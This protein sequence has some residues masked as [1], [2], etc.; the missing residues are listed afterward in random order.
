LTRALPRLRRKG[1]G[2]PRI[3]IVRQTDLYE[4][5]VKREAE[6]LARAGYETEV[7]LMR[8]TERP[9]RAVVDGGVVLISLPARLGRSSKAR[10]ALDYAW[11]WLLAATTLAVRHLRRPYDVVQVNTMPDFLVFAAV[12]PKLLGARVVAY[13]KE[14]VPEL[15]ETLYGTRRLT[16]LLERFEQWA[17]RFADHSLTVT[18][19]LKRLYVERGAPAER[20]T[21][22]LNGADAETLRARDEP[23]PR[24]PGFTLICHGSIEERY[25]QDT[26]IE[27]AALL[28]DELPDLRV[29]FI[30]RGGFAAEMVRR[31]QALGLQD[32]VRF[33]GW[34]TLDRMQDLLRA[35]DA[36][37]VAQKASRYSH[38]V[39]TNK[40]VDY[41]IFGLPVVA[42]R[43]RATAALYDDT[44]I[45]YFAPGDA[46]D[47]AR[48]IARLQDDPRR[49]DELARNGRAAHARHGW[50]VQREAYLAPFR[51][52]TATGTATGA[53]RIAPP[54]G[55]TSST[56][57]SA[58]AGPR[59]AQPAPSATMVESA[60][61]RH[62][63]ATSRGSAVH[64]LGSGAKRA[65][66]RS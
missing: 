44:V 26:I 57:P 62:H 14:P 20:I 47:L 15:T 60:R 48:A 33:D 23:P 4:V 8:S 16:P 55:P 39:H 45:E 27:A 59:I 42:S 1:A 24:E 54:S 52:L 29:V 25:G 28:R 43:L 66:K 40:M 38:L 3:C 41:W 63:A 51:A 6:A 10:Y 49:R 11:F 46:A 30:G 50:A 53:A 22:V 56:R 37:I 32:V 17:I 34:V 18:E 13:M 5:P 21:V 7:L 12:V 31:I 65:T 58:A 36:G 61:R 35:A 19:Q 9:R 64:A 2:R